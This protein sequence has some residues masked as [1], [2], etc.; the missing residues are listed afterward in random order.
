LKGGA[1]REKPTKKRQRSFF[2]ALSF[3]FLFFFTSHRFFAISFRKHNFFLNDQT[4][5]YILFRK[6]HRFYEARGKVKE[7]A[8]KKAPLSHFSAPFSTGNWATR[9]PTNRRATERKKGVNRND[10]KA[11]SIYLA[12]S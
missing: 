8:Q 2:C 7:R 1:E 3:S 6:L 4:L 12:F 10:Q 9:E 11:S 5:S